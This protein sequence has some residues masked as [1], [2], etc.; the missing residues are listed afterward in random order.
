MTDLENGKPGS[1]GEPLNEASELKAL[2]IH[3]RLPDRAPPP[4]SALMAKLGPK[5]ELQSDSNEKNFWNLL[6]GIDIDWGRLAV[7]A[8]MFIL[9]FALPYIR[10][11]DP[12]SSSESRGWEMLT[13]VSLK[14]YERLVRENGPLIRQSTYKVGKL[15]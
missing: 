3:L 2:S 5:K 6:F 4:V 9:C 10:T 1:H 15:F 13:R 12:V 8:L 14:Q 7:A 11:I